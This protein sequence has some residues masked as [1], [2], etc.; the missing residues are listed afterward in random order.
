MCTKLFRRHYSRKKK[1][2]K[3][4]NERE[5]YAQHKI[6]TIKSD[7]DETENETKLFATHHHRSVFYTDNWHD[8][9]GNFLI[10][11][12]LHWATYHIH[13]FLRFSLITTFDSLSHLC[14]S[15]SLTHSGRGTQ[16]EHITKHPICFICVFNA[17]FFV[18]CF[19]FPFDSLYRFSTSCN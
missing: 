2:L 5:I 17:F 8:E 1:I 14:R 6:K 12:L 18:L 19:F 16:I 10:N 9:N 15:P 13:F 11:G 4:K 3:T 7:L